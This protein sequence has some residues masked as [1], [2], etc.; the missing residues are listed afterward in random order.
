MKLAYLADIYQHLDNLNTSMQGA[1]GNILSSPN[2]LLAF[3][4][5]LFGKNIFQKETSKYF[6]SYFK[7]KLRLNMKMSFH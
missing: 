2:K 7:F 4:N 6:R 3:K 1:K 5:K